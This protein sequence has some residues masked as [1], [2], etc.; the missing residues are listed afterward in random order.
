MQVDPQLAYQGIGQCFEQQSSLPPTQVALQAVE[1]MVS[2]EGFTMPDRLLYLALFGPAMV[3]GNSKMRD[4]SNMVFMAVATS[5]KI[6]KSKK[7][8]GTC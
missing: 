4:L 1:R 5:H 7:W 3:A 8:N 6:I 2:A